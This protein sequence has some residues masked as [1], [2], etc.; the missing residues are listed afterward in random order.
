MKLICYKIIL[1]LVGI[2]VITDAQPMNGIYPIGSGGHGIDSFASVQAA[3]NA[4]SSRGLA[5]NVE[6]PIAPGLYLGQVTVRNVTNSNTYQTLFRANQTGVLINASGSQFAFTVENTHNLTVQGLRFRGARGN[7]SACVRFLDSENG[8]VRSCRVG[9]SSQTGILVV[10]GD[11]FQI[12]SLRIEGNLP[13]S[14]SRGLDFQDCFNTQVERCSIYAAVSIGFSVSGGSNLT[15]SYVTVMNASAYGFRIENSPYIS[16]DS[17]RAL[18]QP[19]YGLWVQNATGASFNNCLL[20]GTMSE[21]AYFESCDSLMIFSMMTFG[22]SDRAVS[23]V[24]SHYCSILQLS[25]QS[26]PKRGLL[27]DRSTNCLVDSLQVVDFGPDTAVAIKLD[28]ADRSIFRYSML[29][30]NGAEAIAINRSRGVRFKHTRMIVNIINAGIVLNNSHGIN[31]STCSLTCNVGTAGIMLNGDCDNDTLTEITILGNSRYGIIV[32]DSLGSNSSNLLIANG[33]I[34]GWTESG[35]YMK[36]VQSPQLYYTTIVGPELTGVAGVYL[37]EITDADVRNN[38]IWNK[39]LDSSYC[40]RLEGVYPFRV[41]GS[42]YNDL[43]ASG[44]GGKITRLNDTLYASLSGWQEHG[45]APDLHSLSQDPQLVSENNFH[46]LADSPCRDSGIP[47]SGIIQ[48]LDGD[49]RDPVTPDIGAD[50]YQVTSITETYCFLTTLN[51]T[52]CRNPIGSQILITYNLPNEE[53]VHLRLFDISGRSVMKCNPERKR[54]G[55]YHSVINVST[56]PKGVYLLELQA[57][58]HCAMLKLVRE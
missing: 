35:I 20:Y 52:L 26:H 28:S 31:I 33:F 27:L 23:I 10:R 54:A 45:S 6:F 39:G 38:I 42:D 51:L 44:I 34:T 15:A 32:Q 22:N 1:L 43:Y 3:A 25:I 4:L 18:G 50:E 2:I 29:Y 41:E 47:I 46:L 55:K 5:G 14:E 53:I 17:C 37:Q 12:D 11:N 57:G 21:A 13:G 24:R 7:G 16:F 36:Q 40:Y 30:G 58:R 48:D 56:L 9:D 49:L 19:I 8:S